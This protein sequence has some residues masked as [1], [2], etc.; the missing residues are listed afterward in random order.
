MPS[1]TDKV[2]KPL[3]CFNC[4]Q[5]GHIAVRCPNIVTYMCATAER[6]SFRRSGAVEGTRV[7]DAVLDTGCTQTMVRRELVPESQRIEGEAAAVTCAHGDTVLYPMAEV[8]MEL[9][10]VKLQVTAALSDTLPVSIL[11]GTDVP[12]LGGLLRAN[13]HTV[14]SEGSDQALVVTRAQVRRNEEEVCL[15]QAS[16][17]ASEVQTN[18]ISD[19]SSKGGAGDLYRRGVRRDHC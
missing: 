14:H 18:S 7:E 12:E 17:Q 8:E 15:C 4:N 19:M 6:T 9:E 3:K 1:G 10:G 16:E 13:P 2:K 5:V 11:L